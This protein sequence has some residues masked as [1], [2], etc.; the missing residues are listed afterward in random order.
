MRKAFVIALMANSAPLAIS[1]ITNAFLIYFRNLRSIEDCTGMTESSKEEPNALLGMFRKQPG[2]T[3]H[4]RSL[5]SRLR[6]VR[7]LS[8]PRPKGAVMR[9]LN[10]LLRADT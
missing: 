9:Q 7:M 1:A 2:Q 10:R 4:D 5:R 3:R 6:W 8:E